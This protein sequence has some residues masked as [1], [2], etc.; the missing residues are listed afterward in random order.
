MVGPEIQVNAVAPGFVRTRTYDTM[1]QE[2]IDG[3]IESTYL[4]RFVTQEEIADTFIF[5]AKNDAL[6]GQVIYVDAGFTLK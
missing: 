4:K 5:L 6:T 2:R 3:F 1:T